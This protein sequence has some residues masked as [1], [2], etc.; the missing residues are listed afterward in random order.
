MRVSRYLGSMTRHITAV[1][2]VT[3]SLTSEG[4][5]NVTSVPK[6]RTL[7]GV[8]HHNVMLGRIIR[9]LGQSIKQG[10]WL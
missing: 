7:L 3:A 4:Q 8:Y 9:L 6:T 1:G 5:G 2:P 10:R